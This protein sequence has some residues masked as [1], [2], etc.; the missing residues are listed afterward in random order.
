[1][2][3]RRCSDCQD[4]AHHWLDECTDADGNAV[5]PYFVCKHCEYTCAAAECGV[6]GEIVPVDITR[7]TKPFGTG[8]ICLF[9][10]A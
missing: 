4:Q 10:E 2:S 5:G 3:C 6:C 7:R 8:I 1:M 9:C